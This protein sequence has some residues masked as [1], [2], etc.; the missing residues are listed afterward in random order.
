MA[1]RSRPLIA[2]LSIVLGVAVTATG[3]GS[4]VARQAAP[5]P[6]PTIPP[7][8]AATSPAAA[9]NTLAPQAPA[10]SVSA[11]RPAGPPTEPSGVTPSSSAPES[12]PESTSESTPDSTREPTTAPRTSTPKPTPAKP[13]ALMATGSR[14][15]QV[16]ELQ[17]RLRQL[18]WFTGDITGDYGSA[19]VDGVNGFQGKRGLAQT[20]E[21]DQRTW[22]RL[23]GMTREPTN[24]EMHNRIKAGPAILKAGS[25][26]EKVRN[27]QARLRQLEW[28]SGDITGVYGSLTTASVKGF[29]GKR[30]LPETGEVDQRTWNR[31][32]SMT[33]T[34]SKDVMYNRVPANASSGSTRGLDSRCL[35]GRVVCI[36]KQSNSLTW[37]VNGK[38]QI[39]MDVRFGSD[40][41]PTRNGSFRVFRKTRNG[42]S[43]IYKTP[44]PW[45]MTF[46]GGQAV[47]YSPDFASRGYNGASHG[48]VNV[49]NY[50]GIRWL[51]RQVRLGDRVVVYA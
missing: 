43:T 45:A 28:F 11:S 27:L 20:G 30:G 4:L 39:R 31:L 41:T 29:Q 36:S 14:G 48:C 15:E 7:S 25:R 19:T 6:D 13:R 23:T 26:G 12:A 51:W 38:A 16:R 2:V 17:H 1:D 5:A 42:V 24:D 46:S 18:E 8:A 35:T 32:T 50:D 22:N 40:E 49:R 47:H 3:C 37:V 10:P 34:P 21:V 33:D 9:P 44:M